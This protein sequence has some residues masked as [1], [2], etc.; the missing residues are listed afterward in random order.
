M[1]ASDHMT[2]DTP[3]FH[4]DSLRPLVVDCM[5]VA[6]Q[7]LRQQQQQRKEGEHIQG[8]E[9]CTRLIQCCLSCRSSLTNSSVSAFV[10][11]HP[12]TAQDRNR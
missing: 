8:L 6:I 2:A 7:G 9:V 5:R 1:Q 12:T 10:M 4:S 3:L 11:Q